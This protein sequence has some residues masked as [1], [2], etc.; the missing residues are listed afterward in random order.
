MI[1][2]YTNTLTINTQYMS[3]PLDHCDYTLPFLWDLYFLRYLYY[4]Y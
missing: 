4:P 2:L 1:I 3:S